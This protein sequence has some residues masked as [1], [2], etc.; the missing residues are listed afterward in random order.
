[1]NRIAIT[2]ATVAALSFGSPAFADKGSSCHF[3]GSTPAKEETVLTCAVQRKDALVASGKLDASW[4][5]I[6][7]ERI[8]QVDGKKGKEWKVTFMNPAASDKDKRALYVFLSAPGNVLAANF[9]GK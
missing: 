7:H 3:H 9:T 5:G 1:M 6:K 2:I 4:K 8:E